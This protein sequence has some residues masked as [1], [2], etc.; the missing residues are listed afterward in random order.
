MPIEANSPFL[1]V[2]TRGDSIG[3]AQIHVRDLARAWMAKGLKVHCAV[4]SSGPLTEQLESFGATVHIVEGL[5][6]SINPFSDLTAIWRLR[7]VIRKVKPQVVSAHTA[8]AGLVARLA[9]A[10]SGIKSRLIF[11]AHGWQFADGISRLQKLLVLGVERLCAPL[12]HRII[13]VSDYD[14]QLARAN[15]IARRPRLQCIHNGMPDRPRI[16]H[17]VW[18]GKR[19]LHLIMIAR[20]QMQK[21]H[22]TLFRALSIWENANWDLT[23]VGDGP[24]QSELEVLSRNL[25]IHEKVK[26]LGQR[27]DAPELLEK[28]DLFLLISHWEGFPRSI[29]EAMRAVL[30]VVA[31]DVGGSKESVENGKTGFLVQRRDVESLLR[32]LTEYYKNPELLREHGNYGRQRFERNFTFEA[33]STATWSAYL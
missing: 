31:S 1:F 4:G 20:L 8:K 23:L 33:M 28:A 13:T 22:D 12:S 5:Q 24:R 32:A 25:G 29:L 14:Y 19:N 26:F 27:V 15:H 18:D 21:D 11:T 7:K 17:V 30:P 16:N 3:G 6:R 10:L 2:I 9:G